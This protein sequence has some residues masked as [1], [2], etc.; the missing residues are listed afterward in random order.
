MVN[1]RGFKRIKVN[2][3]FDSEKLSKLLR[4]AWFTNSYA[5][6]NHKENYVIAQYPVV[7]KKSTILEEVIILDPEGID[8]DDREAVKTLI[9]KL[10]NII[11]SQAQLMTG[12]SSRPM[13]NI[14]VIEA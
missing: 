7:L 6:Q 8:Y 14:R 4:N 3:N 13:L 9:I 11:E 5:G 1:L 2:K 10:L 12:K